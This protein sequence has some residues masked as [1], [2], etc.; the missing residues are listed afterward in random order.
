MHILFVTPAYPPFPGGGER[1]VRALAFNLAA[2]G[3]RITAVTTTAQLETHFWLGTGAPSTQMEQDG[4]ISLIRC[5]LRALPGG[6]SALLLWRKL[7]IVLSALPGD[8][9]AVLQKMARLIPPAQQLEPILAALPDDIQLVHGFNLSWEYPLLAG[10]Q[11]ARKRGIP[12]VITPFAHFGTDKRDRLARNA[13]MD[14]QR[15]LLADADAVLALTSVEIDGLREWGVQAKRTA[16]I[17]GG[18]DPLPDLPIGTAVRDSY[19][20]DGDPFA[21]FIGRMSRAKGA[22]DAVKATLALNAQGTPL[23][24]ALIGQTSAEFDQLYA[25]L[26][27]AEKERIRPLGI[28]TD[29]EKHALLAACAMLLLPSHTDSFGIV[30]LEAWA[31]G[32]PVI[33]ARAGGIPGVVDDGENGI[34]VPFGDVAALAA[35]MRRLLTEPD[36]G[37]TMGQRGRQKVQDVF[38]WESVGERVL[39]IY[40]HLLNTAA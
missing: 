27:D 20:P 33:G 32:R 14:H 10:W 34:L 4:P 24:L 35:A 22:L 31:H 39:Q 29:V 5:P 40:D 23:T 38:T 17:S 26:T 9:T 18:M 28:L 30:F 36:L 21:L 6:Q 3:H 11:F 37:K 19:M 1:Y 7:M 12:F 2:R 25:S 15:H 8:Q 16:V 13:T